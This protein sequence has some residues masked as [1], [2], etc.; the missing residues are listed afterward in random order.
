[1]L[2]AVLEAKRYKEDRKSYFAI[3]WIIV[4]CLL[5]LLIGLL[6]IPWPFP[7]PQLKEKSD[8]YRKK[9]RK[10]LTGMSP[11][12]KRLSW[13]LTRAGDN[14]K[15]VIRFLSAAA[16]FSLVTAYIFASAVPGYNRP[17]FEPGI[18]YA[19]E[20][21]WP[22]VSLQ[23][24]PISVVSSVVPISC[25]IPN[26][27]GALAYCDSSLSINSR[28]GYETLVL[29]SSTLSPYIAVAQLMSDNIQ[30][31]FNVTCKTMKVLWHK[32]RSDQ[33]SRS[34]RRPKSA[35]HMGFIGL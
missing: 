9:A 35:A 10:V 25:Y 7:H 18:N 17:K 34:L 11:P 19:T 12:R 14:Y 23:I 32:M 22:S 6:L 8:E 26:G 1:M 21:P 5:V 4:L 27:Y 29:N 33:K 16:S 3:T 15:F 31:G 30:L 28:F 20:I 24:H 2:Y 13:M